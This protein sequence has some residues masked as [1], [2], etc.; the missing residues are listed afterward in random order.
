VEASTAEQGR[1][2]VSPLVSGEA[3][4]NGKL[5]GSFLALPINH[6]QDFG[7]MRQGN[8]NQNALVL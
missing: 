8:Q 7:R 2:S 5:K 3:I 4:D 6:L 1:G